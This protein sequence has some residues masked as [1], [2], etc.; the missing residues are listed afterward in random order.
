MRTIRFADLIFQPYAQH[1]I[2][3]QATT[4]YLIRNKLH[5]RPFIQIRLAPGPLMSLGSQ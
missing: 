1:N 3:Y 2:K 5:Y 4:C